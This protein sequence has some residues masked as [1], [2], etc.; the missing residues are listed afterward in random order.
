MLAPISLHDTA[1]VFITLAGK[2]RVP[3]RG[4]AETSLKISSP[5]WGRIIIEPILSFFDQ[6]RAL[7]KARPIFWS[8][9]SLGSCYHQ[10]HLRVWL[11]LLLDDVLGRGDHDVVV[12][13]QDVLHLGV[14]VAAQPD[15]LGDPG[16]L[17]HVKISRCWHRGTL[18]LPTLLSWVRN[19]QLTKVDN[20]FPAHI[21]PN[22]K[23]KEKVV[24]KM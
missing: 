9:P 13:R 22:Q 15:L 23:R 11:L 4:K 19:Q 5:S 12:L 24:L 10:F 1:I 14:V 2:G 7:F 6:A 18:F 17:E 21:T 8:S 3:F 16:G 20:P